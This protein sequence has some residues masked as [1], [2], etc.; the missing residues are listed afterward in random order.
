MAI[1]EERN[2]QPT[3]KKKVCSLC[4]AKKKPRGGSLEEIQPLPNCVLYVHV[5]QQ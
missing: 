4:V 1:I 2:V 3:K 5:V